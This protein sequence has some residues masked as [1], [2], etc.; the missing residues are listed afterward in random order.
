MLRIWPTADGAILRKI[1]QRAAEQKQTTKRSPARR[2]RKT[3]DA[4]T[5]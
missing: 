5:D 1:M 4:A 2:T 3:R